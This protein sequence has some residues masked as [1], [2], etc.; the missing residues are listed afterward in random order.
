MPRQNAPKSE[1]T[2]AGL[3]NVLDSVTSEE[4]RITFATVSLRLS[5]INF[6]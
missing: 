6:S 5:P 4:G 2:L 1:V 3:L